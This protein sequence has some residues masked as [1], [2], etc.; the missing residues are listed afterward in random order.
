MNDIEFDLRFDFNE[1][2]KDLDEFEQEY[3]E[4]QYIREVK[5]KYMDYRKL[6]EWLFN[7]WKVKNGS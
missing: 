7:N 6:N 4:R 2:A 1:W 3:F 5:P